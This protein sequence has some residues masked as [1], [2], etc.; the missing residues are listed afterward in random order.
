MRTDS[1]EVL[2]QPGNALFLGHGTWHEGVPG[3]RLHSPSQVLS[4]TQPGE[5]AALLESAER[6]QAEGHYVA[7]YLAYEAG[8]GFELPTHPPGSLAPLAWLAVYPAEH[9]EPVSLSEL[10]RCCSPP[11]VSAVSAALNVTR[12]QYRRALA[13]IKELIA[14]GDTYQVNYT[15]HARFTAELDPLAYFLSLVLSHPVPY[16][17][18]LNLG[19]VQILSLSPELF[20]QRRGGLLVSRP[21]KGTRKRGRTPEEDRAVAAELVASEKDRAENLMIL[22]MVRNDLGRVCE[23]GSITVPHMFQAEK[24]RSVWQMTSTVTGK[25]RRRASLPDI[26]AATFP[27]ASVTGAPK[28]RTMQII[29]DLEPEPRGVYTG[30]LGLLLPGGDFTFNLPIRTL[31]H[32]EGHFDLGIGAGIV[33]DSDPDSEYEET[34]LKSSFAFHLSPDLRLRETLLL[35]RQGQYAYLQEHLERLVRSADYWG[36]ACDCAAIA[37]ELARFAEQQESLPLVLRLELGQTGQLTLASRPLPEPPAEPVRVRLSAQRTDS[38]DRFLYH[39][40]NRRAVYDRELER[41]REAGFFEVIFCNEHGRLTEGAITNLFLHREGQW[42]TPP[43]LEG[44]LPGLWR[45]RFLEENEA[46]EQPITPEDLAGATRVVIGNSV[47]GAIEVGEVCDAEG[48]I[49]WRRD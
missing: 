24:Y 36:F 9:A 14:A 46:R 16:A 30:A 15:C 5:I 31:V 35:D 34:W 29:R 22:D 27:G 8:A 47:R 49:L 13:A 32:R 39:K 42:V 10:S 12:E 17:A 44:L 19:P 2:G 6:H 1:L 28:R 7:G 4:A 20:L 40:T 3:L 18:F 21:M 25:L 23:T 41:A 33:W 43:V 26:L 45:A 48:R 37:Q 38:A 11:E